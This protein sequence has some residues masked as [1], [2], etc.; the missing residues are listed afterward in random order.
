MNDNVLT[1]FQ[2]NRFIQDTVKT[3]LNMFFWVR[4]EI[5]QI[6]ENYSGHCYL[7][8]VEKDQGTNRIIAQSRGTIWANVFRMLK[9]YFETTTGR[10]FSEGLKILVCVKV[11]FHEVYGL[12][13]N[14]SDIDPSYTIGDL[15]LKKAEI[16]KRLKEEGVFE[17]NRELSLPL[18]PQRIAIISSETAAGY[19]DFVTHLQNNSFRYRFVA[20]LFPAFMQGDKAEDSIVRSLEHIYDKIRNYDVVAIIRGGGSQSDL[21]CYDSYWLASNVAQFPVP[22]ITGIGH[23]ENDSVVDLVAHTRVKTPTAVAGFLIDCLGRF[24][25]RVDNLNQMV[26]EL[27]KNI[28]SENKLIL[29]KTLRSLP[30]IVKERIYNEKSAIRSISEL[31]SKSAESKVRELHYVHKLNLNNLKFSL[32]HHFNS[33]LLHIRQRLADLKNVIPVKISDSKHM[34]NR[35]EK[36]AALANPESILKKGFSIT[37]LNNVPLKDSAVVKIKDKISTRLHKGI[38]ISEVLSEG[39]KRHR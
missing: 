10:K 26:A 24:E 5:A 6:K 36:I 18:V 30:V 39:K 16:I 3:N 19:L 9:P 2:L 31:I 14:I 38:L 34:L 21:S 33:R 13:L 17:M 28:L 7:E 29:D 27:T 20:K 22:V 8:L 1:L 35:Y 12:S 37:Y 4:A 15:A 23:E 11:E 25:E 32:K